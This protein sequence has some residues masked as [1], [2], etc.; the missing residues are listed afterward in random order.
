MKYDITLN[1]KQMT[2]DC[3]RPKSC[4]HRNTSNLFKHLSLAHPDIFIEL[5]DR[6]VSASFINSDLIVTFFQ[7][8]NAHTDVIQ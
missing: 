7:L 3:Y 1:T 8:I 2:K 5:G 4:C 6:Q